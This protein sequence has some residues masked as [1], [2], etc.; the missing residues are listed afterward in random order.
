[1]KTLLHVGCGPLTIRQLPAYFSA[2]EWQ[3]IRVD[4]DPAVKPDLV[5]DTRDLSL[6]EDEAVDAVYSSHNIEHV[7][8]FEVLTVLRE[9]H[10]VLRPDGVLC[11]KCPDVEQVSIAIAQGRR[12]DEP[13]YESPAGPITAIDILYG[14]QKSIAAGN[15]FM[16]HKMA[17]SSDTLAR[18]LL[19]A[20]FR[21]VVVLRDS[22]Y[23]LS[24]VAFRGAE[25]EIPARDMAEAVCDQ[26]VLVHEGRTYGFGMP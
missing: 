4:I 10:R 22:I 21:C 6:L 11:I 23:G 8:S 3:E 20:G 14:F 13:L 24:A 5:A 9:F 18:H 26:P 15:S 12:P 17:F 16:A 7:W 25:L 19:D 1:M 2:G